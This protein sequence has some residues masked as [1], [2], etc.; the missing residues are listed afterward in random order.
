MRSQL[1]CCL[2]VLNQALAAAGPAVAQW[3]VAHR[4]AS[5]E[6][7]ENT[8]SAFQLAWEQG[9][10]AIEGDCYLTAD[11]QIVF[12]HD[13]T[14]ERVSGVKLI[15]AHT[16]LPKLRTLDVGSWKDR[17]FSQQR[18][19]TLE[20]VCATVPAGKRFFIEVKCGP[21]IVPQLQVALS[22]THLEKHQIVVISFNREV[23]QAAKLALPEIECFWLFKFRQDK[24]H[25]HWYPT[26]EDVIA[27]AQRIGADGVDLHA[28]MQR[29]DRKFVTACHEAG[30]SVHA[31]TVDD[32]AVATQ[33]RDLGF[34]SITTNRPGFLRQAMAVPA[35]AEQRGQPVG[36]IMPTEGVP[37]TGLAQGTVRSSPWDRQPTLAGKLASATT[38]SPLIVSPKEAVD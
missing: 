35:K 1:F 19:P 12:T 24:T 31:W 3:I 27:T 23:V 6:A 36:S 30:L 20:E 34:A 9:A 22:K 38:P 26:T 10:D 21:E 14:T 33:L 11:G 4:G 13:D 5:A 32:P 8:L 15:V 18:M 25:G 7:P 29:V 17:K 2:L 37:P 28:T 16:T